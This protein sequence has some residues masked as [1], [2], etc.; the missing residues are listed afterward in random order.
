MTSPHTVCNSAHSQCPGR[1]WFVHIFN[2]YNP[3]C[4][5]LSGVN[6]AVGGGAAEG[7]QISSKRFVCLNKSW[8]D[9]YTQDE[10]K[11][12]FSRSE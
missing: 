5:I 2:L 12:S 4:P 8:F 11:K 3:L 6:T 7:E 10:L 9:H 1:Y